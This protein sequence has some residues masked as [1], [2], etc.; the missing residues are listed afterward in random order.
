M[1]RLTG[2]ISLSKELRPRQIRVNALNPGLK[3]GFGRLVG[4]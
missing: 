3:D 4:V 1:S 2:K